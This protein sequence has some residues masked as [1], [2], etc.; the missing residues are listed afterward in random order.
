VRIHEMPLSPARIRELIEEAAA[1][2]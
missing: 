1:R 2:S